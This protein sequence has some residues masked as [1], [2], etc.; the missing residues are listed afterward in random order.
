M[1]G[2]TIINGKGVSNIEG[3]SFK[4]SLRFEVSP[5]HSFLFGYNYF[6]KF[7]NDKIF[8]EDT[9][10]I[11]GL[12]GVILNLQKLK[13]AYGI[14]DNFSLI[15]TVF[16]RYGIHFISE[17]KGEFNGFVFD[18]KNSELF[19]FNNKTGTKQIFY[20]SFNAHIMISQSI[21]TIIRF[22][23]RFKL[24]SYLNVNAVYSMLTF[25]GLLESETLV[26]GITKLSAGK[27]V[28]LKNSELKEKEYFSFNN[29]AHTIHS[30]KEAIE[31]IDETIT[32]AIKLEYDK[33]IAYNYKHLATLSGGLDSRVNV[34]IAHKLGY[35]SNTF[36]F[37]EPNYLD[38]VISKKIASSLNLEHQFISLNNGLYMNDL[39]ENTSITNGSQIFTGA[40]HYNYSLKQLDLTNY[41]ALHT[42]QIGDAIFGGLLTKGANENF[43]S[44]KISNLFLDKVNINSETL[45]KYKNE[46]VFKLYQRIFNITHAGSYTTE[47]HKS[48]LLSPFLD[49]EVLST[50]LSISPKL[51]YNQDIYID[52]ICEKHPY[53]T[54]FK[55]ERTG[56]K[57]NK[58]WKTR[59]SRYTKKLKNEFLKYSNSKHKISMTPEDYWL[60]NTQEVHDFYKS[61]YTN[62][63][64]SLKANTEL[65]NDIAAYY[66][67]GG[68]SAKSI[69][70][71]I[72]EVIKRFKLKV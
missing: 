48:Y 54:K 4:K 68:A 42:G 64:N 56:F 10:Y 22:K 38:D 45:S 70:L 66:Q 25:G 55:W 39:E 53:I 62:Y 50:A 29:V 37:S 19:F 71:T 2:F 33:D 23:E 31:R 18:K 61:F 65:F 17:L 36:C 43:L 58:K 72:L 14:S 60:E 35:R 16:K 28:S 52:W 34:M 57:P 13:N 46:E 47:S 26:Q 6:Q 69:I 11:I 9:D 21:D 8:T 40:A 67:T 24:A 32:A 15:T 7:E 49:D 63:A 51:K 5:E 1:Y 59:A 44:K 41:G 20:A 3:L 12:D 30:K 27:Y